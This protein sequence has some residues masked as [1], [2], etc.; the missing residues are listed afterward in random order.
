VGTGSES[1]VAA[2]HAA[3]RRH[4]TSRVPAALLA[5]PET[6]AAVAAVV[7]FGFFALW[8][9]RFLTTTSLAATLTLA[10]E[11][12]IVAV[13]VTLLMI[14]GEFDLSVG[15]VLGVSS[16]LVP[17]TMVHYGVSAVVAILLALIAAALIGA[18]QGVLVTRW[19]IPSFIVTLG[20]LLFW[21]SMLQVVTKGFPVSIPGNP[22][23][24][25]VFSSQIGSF[26]VSALW[27]LALALVLGALL[28]RTRLGNWIFASGGNER[29]AR[30]MGVP[31]DRVRVL[32][33]MLTASA[34]A[35]V[36]IIQAA[37]FTSVDTTRGEG[38]E[39]EAVA[40]VVIGG[41]HLTGGYGS[42]AG[43]VLGCLMIGMIRNGLVLAGV[44][45]YWYQGIIGLLLVGAVVINQLTGRS[46]PEVS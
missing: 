21:R 25:T 29:A 19:R 1:T 46:R 39:F 34:A 11:L 4:L 30:S 31:V 44:A 10:A 43:T 27:F 26:N 22:G 36:G 2:A 20:G 24:L 38:L 7:L 18:L 15:S 16:L 37:R 6:G 5:R 14:A 8:A 33:F 41:S 32:L 12:G 35:L 45:S 13:A 9:P 3:A 28:T 42:I 17:Y 40:A 23:V